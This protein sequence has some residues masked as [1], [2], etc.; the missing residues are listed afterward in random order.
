MIEV[1]LSQCYPTLLKCR[2]WKLNGRQTDRHYIT[3]DQSRYHPLGSKS[4]IQFKGQ[5]GSRN[6]DA[7]QRIS[8]GFPEMQDQ[9][10][11]GPS[12]H[13]LQD[14]RSCNPC[15]PTY[16]PCEMKG[17]KKKR[18]L[19]SAATA[20][21]STYDVLIDKGPNGTTLGEAW[22]WEAWPPRVNRL[23]GNKKL[24][25]PACSQTRLAP[26]IDGRGALS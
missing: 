24:A 26:P 5:E 14:T 7:I 11:S 13:R 3:P 6:V 4:E 19:S 1:F 18:G 25:Y 15:L 23:T 16:L 8:R 17:W 22:D 21:A 10:G 9:V 2:R 12:K 20:A